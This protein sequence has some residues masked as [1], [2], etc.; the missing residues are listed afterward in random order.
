MKIKIMIFLSCVIILSSCSS[1]VTDISDKGYRI[2]FLNLNAYLAFD[3]REY[4]SLDIFFFSDYPDI[5]INMFDFNLISNNIEI[6]K[7]QTPQ[8]T[9]FA[10][11]DEFNELKGYQLKLI[12]DMPSEGKYLIDTVAYTINN[13]R[14]VSNIGFIEIDVVDMQ[15]TLNDI[16]I[17]EHTAF[18]TAPLDSNPVLRFNIVP[19]IG[20]VNIK[21]IC[22]GNLN[23]I[24]DIHLIPNNVAIQ[25]GDSHLFNIICYAGGSSLNLI[26]R[27]IL[28]YD[29]NGQERITS[30][31]QMV[32]IV[33]FDYIAIL[34]E[35]MENSIVVTDPAKNGVGVDWPD[36]ISAHYTYRLNKNN[37]HE[38]T[39]NT[40][41]PCIT[42][43][44]FKT[45]CLSI[46]F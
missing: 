40:M 14:Y 35:I 28:L 5:E 36:N 11:S 17:K 20:N 13:I 30:L 46:A 24:L 26:L 3:S 29:Y 43:K 33:D 9:I 41:F 31:R 22:L 10:S 44:H 15:E 2:A 8:I 42:D 45:K 25:E 32:S 12:C 6:C 16:N 27:P 39:I 38:S 37:F 19:N 34:E 4:F 1:T 21:G 18:I 23:E 7:A